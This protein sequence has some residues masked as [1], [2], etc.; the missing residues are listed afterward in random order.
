VELAQN[1]SRAGA[2]KLD[3]ALKNGVLT[4]SDNGRGAGVCESLLVLADSAWSDEVEA[5]QN[6]AGWGIFFLIS[7]SKKIIFRSLFGEIEIECERFLKDRKYRESAL[8][9]VD[10]KKSSA[11]FYVEVVL[12]P[13]VPE[14]SIVSQYFHSHSDILRFFPMD[15]TVNGQV[16]EKGKIDEK[17]EKCELKLGYKGNKVGVSFNGLSNLEYSLT[18][19]SNFAPRIRTVWY[20]IDIKPNNS[21]VILNVT[22]ASPV[23]PVLPYRNSIQEDSK[24][25]EFYEFIKKE[26]LKYCI[27]YVSNKRNTD[28]QSL[29]QKLKIIKAI[30]SQD[31]LDLLDRFYVANSEP[32]HPEDHYNS[33]SFNVVVCKGEKI[34][35][36]DIRLFINGKEEDCPDDIFLPEGV[37]TSVEAPERKPNWLRVKKKIYKLN[38]RHAPKKAYKGYFRW[39]KAKITWEKEA[40]GVVGIVQGDGDGEIYYADT[41][42][43]SDDIV[44][45]VFENK[46][47]YEDGDKA[48]SQRYYFDEE[49]K[50]DIS[51]VVKEYRLY[52]LFDGFCEAGIKTGSIKSI[53]VHK[54]KVEVMIGKKKKILKLAA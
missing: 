35:S 48:D 12:K 6:P 30:A 50:K 33:N 38:V 42:R 25:Q 44:D 18:S 1:A 19:L 34:V 47:Y 28:E 36:E 21:A 43:D 24:L 23:T 4:A 7:I 2:S 14:N 54:N 22:Q 5:Q 15:I 32:Y 16:I 3:I 40:V 52:D 27:S 51:N 39:S 20:G 46:V 17:I 9:L 31:D 8:G 11:G 41:A 53:L 13:E 10:R 29:V 45:S 26:V 49:I 37:I